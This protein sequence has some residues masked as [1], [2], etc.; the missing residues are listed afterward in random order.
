MT[1]KNYSTTFTTNKTPKQV[2]DAINN[3]RGWWSG[4]IT[5]KTDKPGAQFTYRYEDMHVSKQKITEF[6]PGKRVVW[7]IVDGSLN[8]LKDKTEWTGTDI[9][10]DITRK[11]GKTKVTF[12]HVGLVSQFECYEACADAWG[13][14]VKVNLRKLIDTGEDQPDPF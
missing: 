1:T 8:F 2:F 14:L 4:D 7:H 5:G 11:D 12:T 9:V 10:F 6:V 13:T 3:V